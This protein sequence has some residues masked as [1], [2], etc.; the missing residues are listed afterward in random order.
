M[1][2]RNKK[3]GQL[4]RPLAFWLLWSTIAI[5]ICMGCGFAVLRIASDSIQ[6]LGTPSDFYLWPI[7]ACLVAAVTGPIVVYQLMYAL[8]E[9]NQ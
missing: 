5:A 4:R 6:N 1:Q 8:W 7:I 9:K 3:S 2:T